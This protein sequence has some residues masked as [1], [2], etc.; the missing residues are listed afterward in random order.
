V[1][2]H[3]NHG[4]PEIALRLNDGQQWRTDDALRLGM[5]GMRAQLAA[6]VNEMQA[7]KFTPSDYAALADDLQAQTDYIVANCKLPEDA[8]AQLHIVLGEILEGMAAMRSGESAS[9]GA[10]RVARA[11]E[12]YAAHFDHPGW[13]AI[14]H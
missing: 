8:D 1:S 13:A 4:S 5:E 6:A 12:A 10:A 9:D 3:E 11:L 14:G 2:G 7:G